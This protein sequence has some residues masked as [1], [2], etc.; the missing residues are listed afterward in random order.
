MHRNVFFSSLLFFLVEG[1]T[2][3]GN[4]KKGG[5]RKRNGKVEE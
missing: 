3:G 1:E 5:T 2:D 4:R